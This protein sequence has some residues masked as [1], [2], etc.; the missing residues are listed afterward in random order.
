MR[1]PFSEIETDRLILREINPEIIEYIFSN[2]G[3]KRLRQFFDCQS[4]EALEEERIRFQKKYI[5]NLQWSFKN[6][7]FVEKTSGKVI[8]DGG[9]H[10]WALPHKRAEI[11]YSIKE[12]QWNKGYMTEALS[13][14]IEI[15][16]REMNL[17][18]IEAFVG[19]QNGPSLRLMEKFG[20]CREGYMVKRY[21]YKE[22]LTDLLAFALL[23][24]TFESLTSTEPD[25]LKN[26]V[27]AFEN[28]T[29]PLQRWTHEA[30]LSTGL[31]YILKDGKAAALCKIRSGIISYNLAMGVRNT[32]SSGYHETIT[33]FWVWLLDQY[34]K[35]FGEGKNIEE[36][37]DAFVKSHYAAKELPLKFY[38]KEA[39]MSTAARGQWLAPDIQ[40]L[41][42]DGI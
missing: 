9:F 24:P 30:H 27:K 4:D 28:H 41:D 23:K 3:Q 5:S 13:K 21:W 10:L 25:A 36:L 6:W 19:P 7:L 34:L 26:I 16:F 2:Y 14:I 40:A 32:S 38:S 20:F 18:R 39:L 35:H 17:Y 22:E 29:L 42:F 37:A 12:E 31:W 1:S 15:G 11:G 33:V 8:G